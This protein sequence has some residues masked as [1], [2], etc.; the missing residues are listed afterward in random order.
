MNNSWSSTYLVCTHRRRQ[1]SNLPD[2]C[3]S[4]SLQAQYREHCNERFPSMVWWLGKD[5]CISPGC[6]PI[7]PNNQCQ[8]YIPA[9]RSRPRDVD[10]NRRMD[11]PEEYFRD[12]DRTPRDPGRNKR[13]SA[14]MVNF[15]RKDSRSDHRY[16]PNCRGNRDSCYTRLSHNEFE[17]YHSSRDRNDKLIYDFYRSILHWWRICY[18]RC[19]DW[20]I[21]RC[22]RWLR[23]RTRCQIRSRLK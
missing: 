10:C 4:W 23:N 14:R 5:R 2:T 9:L 7:Y 1:W 8:L 18:L 19:K 11:F 15:R 20:R 3:K 6:I 17:D 16:K 13:H 22:S 21:D 12:N